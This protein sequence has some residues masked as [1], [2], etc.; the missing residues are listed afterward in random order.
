MIEDARSGVKSKT[1]ARLIEK[2]TK[3]PSMGGI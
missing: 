1:S 3:A 2:I